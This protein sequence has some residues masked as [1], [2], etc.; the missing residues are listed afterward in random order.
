MPWAQLLRAA[1]V[2]LALGTALTGSG[3]SACLGHSSYG[4]AVVAL[5]LGT[6]L[7]GSGGSACLGHSSY[8]Q[9]W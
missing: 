7:T 5:A 8:G 3:G 1:V 9:R 4:I 6:A 2:A